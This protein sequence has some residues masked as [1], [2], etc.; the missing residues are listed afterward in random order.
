MK[1]VV[2]LGEPLWRAVGSR[3]LHL[4]FDQDSVSVADVL[5]HLQ[6]SYPAFDKAYQG[7][8][9]PQTMPYN[10][11]VNSRIV[12][13][14]QEADWLL[15]D[16]DTLYIF[17]PAVGGSAQPLPREFYDRPTLVVA[18][19][20][21]GQLLVRYV[22]G[23][24]LSGRIVEVEAYIG[25]DD[26][27]SHASRGLTERTRPMYGPP[28]LAY[29]YLIYGMHHCLNVVTEREGFP[30]AVLIRGLEPLEGLE[31][32]RRRRA[33]RPLVM[34]TDGP[35][36]LCQAMAIDRRLNGHDLTIGQELWL[37]P[38]LP[39]PDEHVVRTS[40]IGVRGDERARTVPWRLL[41]TRTVS[42]ARKGATT[43]ER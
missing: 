4:S 6:A 43:D 26:K 31:A 36:K 11:F 13:R 17:L 22:D 18:R 7:H 16:G 24:R 23:Q 8:S 27:A 37:E 25:E 39:V 19:E 21:L 34:L 2:R 32:M 42:H 33:G 29:V 41:D 5:D 1:I 20:L 38:G 14:G 10:L 40:R 9:L 30:A 35:A 12:P 28:G 3:R 15:A